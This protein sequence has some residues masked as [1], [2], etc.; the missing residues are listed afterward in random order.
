MLKLLRF[1]WTGDW[2]THHWEPVGQVEIYEDLTSSMPV[3]RRVILR[4]KYC[5]EMKR[6]SK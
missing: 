6:F 4:C 2:H 5:G 1:L 3:Q